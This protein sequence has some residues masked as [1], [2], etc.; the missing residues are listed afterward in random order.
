MNFR[1]RYDNPTPTGE[2]VP[3]PFGFGEIYLGNQTTV[4]GANGYS[5]TGQAVLDS[6]FSY[7]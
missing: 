4:R 7:P 2:P 5:V 3:N 6:S 1:Q